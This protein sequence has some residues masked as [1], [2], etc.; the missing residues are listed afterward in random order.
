MTNQVLD[1]S[2]AGFAELDEEARSREMERRFKEVL[3]LPEGDRFPHLRGMILA[4]YALEPETLH[5]FT[6]SRLRAWVSMAREDLASAHGVARGYDKV[7]DSLPA[8]MAM[9]RASIV[10]TVARQDLNAEE[11]AYLF[12]VIPSLV[13]HL[14][15]TPKTLEDG[16]TP[17]PAAR[18]A[19]A[20][21]AGPTAAKP[22]WR[23]W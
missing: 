23:F 5:S 12:D 20:G 18:M 21:G 17:M 16:R 3:A 9:R 14:P 13:R 11:I 1:H 15:R 10:Q 7:F 6:R 8:E 22:W 2:W 19:T 4:E